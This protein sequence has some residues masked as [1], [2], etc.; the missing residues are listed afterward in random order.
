MSTP[1]PLP[2]TALVEAL[3]D[4]RFQELQ[5]ELLAAGTDVLDRDA[6]ALVGAVGRVLRDLVPDD[7][8]AEAVT[9]YLA[10]LH[11]LYLHWAAGRPVRIVSRERLSAD[12]SASPPPSEPQPGTSYLQLPERQVWA[13][14]AAGAAHEPLDGLFVAADQ[15]RVFVLAVLGFRP[16]REGF[17]TVEVSVP[18]PVAA[19][20]ARADGSALFS[21]VLPAGDRMGFFSIT[22]EAELAWLALLALAAAAG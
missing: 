12:L 14:P 3:G 19:A 11:A 22:S 7:A 5:R 16:E 10:L 8:P 9:S 2:W 13:P 20:P 18:R 17:T 21:S 4:E 1:R 15:R 6:F